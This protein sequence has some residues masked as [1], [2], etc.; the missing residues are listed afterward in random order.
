MYLTGDLSSR[1]W[2]DIDVK[3]KSEITKEDLLKAKKD[4]SFQ[5]IDVINR[6]YFDA[7]NNQWKEIK[8]V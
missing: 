3:F 1:D 7:E 8:L 5:V 4:D 2:F 6:K